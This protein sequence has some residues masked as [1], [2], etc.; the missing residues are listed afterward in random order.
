MVLCCFVA[1]ALSRVQLFVTPWTAALRLLCPSLWFPR[2]CSGSCPLSRWC[3][4]TV[5]SSATP[6]FFCLQ[7]F[8]AS[9]SFP[10]NW[11]FM[12]CDLSIGASASVFP[13]NIQGWFPLGLTGL[14]S[15]LSKGLPRVFSSTTIRMHQFFVV[16]PSSSSSSF[17]CSA[18]LM[19]QLTHSYMTTEKKWMHVYYVLASVLSSFFLLKTKIFLFARHLIG[20][21]LTMGKCLCLN[22]GHPFW[23]SLNSLCIFWWIFLDN[24]AENRRYF[25][26]W[27]MLHYGLKVH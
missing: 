15:W 16:Q 23:F 25:L 26:S 17:F 24:L 4:L 20:N 22:L 18:F 1:Q 10:M 14:I 21:H 7:S 6:Y 12:S 5:S 8:P 13:I 19:I 9:R 27:S 3:Y 11:L 2:I